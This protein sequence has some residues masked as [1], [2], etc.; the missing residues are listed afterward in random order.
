MPLADDLVA[1]AAL[2]GN[3]V[4]AAAATDVWETVRDGVGRLFGRGGPEQAELAG[5]RLEETRRQLAAV[6]GA[7]LTQAR[8]AL[9]AQWTTRLADL[10]EE[11]PGIEADL[12]TLMQEIQAQLPAGVVLAA[13]HSVAAGRDLSIEASGGGVA[14]GVMHASAI[15]GM[16]G[17][18]IGRMNYQRPQIASQPVSLAPRPVFLTG[19]EELLGELDMRLSGGGDGGPRIIALCGLGGA[20]KTSVAVE[21]AYRHL[22]ETGLVWQVPAEDPTVIVAEFARLAGLLGAQD[23]VA[24]GDPVASVHAVL[25][26]Y[27]PEWLLVFDSAPDRASVER[28]LPPAGP[29]R[30]LITSQSVL[31]PPGQVL[32]VPV[33]D[34][35][36]AVGF[37]VSRTG[38][39]DGPAAP[40]L[41]TELG[42]LPLALEQAAAYIQATGGSLARYLAS[43]R[44]RRDGLLARGEPTGYRKTVA[45]TW[46]LAFGQL[47]DS[48]PAAV[49]LLRLLACCASE[50]VPL[51]LLLQ[52]RP[53][54]ARKFGAEVAPVLV[55]LLDDPLAVGDAI[56][57]LRRYSLVTPAGDGLVSV[58][59]LVQAVTADQMSADVASQWREAAAALVEAAIPG[60]TDLPQAWPVC[61]ALLPHAQAALAGDSPGMDRLANYLGA[62]GS[63]AAAAELLQRVLDARERSLGA[64]HPDTLDARG[65]LATWTGEAGDATGARDQYAALVPVVERVLGPEHPDTLTTRNNLAR[66][67]GRAGEAAGARDQFAALLPEV[68]R[69]LGAEHPDTLT[70]RG[71][72]AT[73]TGQAG[74]AAGA[75]DQ[76]A[77]LLPVRERVLGPEHPDTLS[78]RNNLAR[79]TGQAGDAAGARDQFAALLPEVERVLGAEHRTSWPPGATW[80]PGPGR[81]GMRPGPAT[82]MPRCCPSSS[83]SWA[84][85]TRTPWPPGITS[86]TGLGRPGMRPGPATSSPRCCLW[87]SGSWAPSTQTL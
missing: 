10:L 6:T 60:D 77:A 1:L 47:E 15:A 65:N 37:L 41:A 83:G 14:A 74:D 30:V 79:W 81:R 20:G 11:D 12:R 80:P 58:H 51:T 18:A 62:Q 72:L 8:A 87:L 5:R 84:L 48:A 22:A 2:A 28:F 63:Y 53:G 43:F 50:A 16:G 32:D 59:R 7:E 29:G 69:V 76:Y 66:F 26:A 31:W 56:A 44:Q 33:L 52:P 61:A 3:S 23:P 75:R 34:A 17:T 39:P 46:S 82:S 78:N 45:T 24:P 4:V 13:D 35:E 36:V 71:N 38:D 9:E 57:A 86:P 64:E 42:G 25:A 67:T 40:E 55:P 27:S 70:V 54:L 21:Y 68:E 73:W 49:G 19:R 85:S